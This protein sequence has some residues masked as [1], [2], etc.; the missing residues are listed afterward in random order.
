MHRKHIDMPR[1]DIAEY[2]IALFAVSLISIFSIRYLPHILSQRFD[3]FRYDIG[4]LCRCQH[5]VQDN[6]EDN[7]D[8][9]LTRI[10]EQWIRCSEAGRCINRRE[11]RIKLRDETMMCAMGQGRNDLRAQRSSGSIR[12]LGQFRDFFVQLLSGC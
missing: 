5:H 4:I 8:I 2:L 7:Q 3:I 10:T 1:Y 9:T 6:L 11:S 12:A